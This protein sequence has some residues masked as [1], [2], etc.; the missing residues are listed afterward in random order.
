MLIALQIPDVPMFFQ[1]VIII[2][3]NFI[4]LFYLSNTEPFPSNPNRRQKS[5][6]EGLVGF[7]FIAVLTQT[8]WVPTPQTRFDYA[9]L[10][11]S[12][13]QLLI[14][15]NMLLV[16]GAQLLSYRLIIIKFAKRL[17]CYSHLQKLEKCFQRRGS[18]VA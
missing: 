9:W 7:F 11:F 13:I 17:G 1:I 15:P 16:I 3:I 5:Y 4:Q 12:I 8:D 6:N 18:E 10:P 14:V 2:T